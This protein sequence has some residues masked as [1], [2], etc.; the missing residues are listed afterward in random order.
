[1]ISSGFG[2]HWHFT[3]HSLEGGR[4]RVSLPPQQR[5]TCS[6]VWKDWQWQTEPGAAA[7]PAGGWKSDFSHDAFLVGVEVSIP[8]G[9]MW[10]SFPVTWN[11][12]LSLPQLKEVLLI[13]KTSAENSPPLGSH[14]WPPDS[15]LPPLICFTRHLSYCKRYSSG[16]NHSQADVLNLKLFE[17]A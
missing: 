17:P 8:A 5:Q 6:F 2:E 12:L 10:E 15:Q 7:A 3:A 14:P 11:T 4:S 1:M 9:L 13:L 16:R